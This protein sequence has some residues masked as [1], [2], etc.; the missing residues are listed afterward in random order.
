MNAQ[1]FERLL[2]TVITISAVIALFTPFIVSHYFHQ[3]YTFPQFIVFQILVLLMLTAW[4]LLAIADSKYRPNWKNPVLIGVSIFIISLL[5]TLPFSIDPYRSF[6]SDYRMMGVLNYLYYFSWFLVLSNTFKTWVQWKKL[7]MIANGV[8][9]AVS[10]VGI[11]EIDGVFEKVRIIATLGN[12]LYVASYLLLGIG[13]AFLLWIK[14]SNK[15]L[16]LFFLF[17]IFVNLSALLLTS[18]RGPLL[19]LVTSTVV[20]II[21][22]TATSGIKKKKKVVLASILTASILLCSLSVAWLRSP[23]GTE[24]GK[25]SL[26]FVVSRIVYS[27]LG[28]DRL[29]IWSIALQAYKEHPVAGWGLE[30]FSVAFNKYFDPAVQTHLLE[31]WYDRV[32]N[33][34]LD[35]LY[36]AGAIGLLGYLSIWIG[37]FYALHRKLKESSGGKD[38]YLYFGLFLIFIAH[39]IQMIFTFDTGSDT[40]LIFFLLALATSATSI[41]EKQTA[42]KLPYAPKFSYMAAGPLI[43]LMFTGQY[44]GNIL[45]ASKVIQKIRAYNTVNS[46]HVLALEYYKD[47]LEPYTFLSDEM[48]RRMVSELIPWGDDASIT[49][50]ELE[51]LMKFASEEMVMSAERNDYDF[52]TQL[53]TAKILRLLSEYE[54]EALV[55]AEEIMFKALELAP[56]RADGYEELGEISL[57]RG[58]LDASVYWFAEAYSRAQQNN[59]ILGSL[60][61]RFAELNAARQD[62]DQAFAQL[63]LAKQ[64]GYAIYSDTRI[65]I[66]LA[67]SYA[68]GMDMDRAVSYVDRVWATYPT[69]AEVI[70][71]RAI[72]NYYADNQIV[73]EAMLNDLANIDADL[74][75]ETR[76]ELGIE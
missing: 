24:W 47:S 72:I 33:Q 36:G 44:F 45:P 2:L 54:P 61:M 8:A 71:A 74:A 22:F 34:Y 28:S 16:K 38:R 9:L 66:R 15:N 35:L 46:D 3:P 62:F 51:Q 21:L 69:N 37:A 60:R 63:D 13:I 18:S 76:I 48:R 70:R 75:K 50:P 55:T 43:A 26:P 19:A 23:S 53:W 29:D 10:A 12:P 57:A 17:S 73:A 52:T 56:N 39:M 30:S 68:E 65:A 59:L 42:T 7:L 49:S 58:N 14:E 27:D 40:L 20:G 4:I 31:P 64:A 11:A 5:I 6:W 1:K 67:N 41:K 32:H 25:N